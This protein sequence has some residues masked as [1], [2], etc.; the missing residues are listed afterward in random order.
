MSQT[1]G[2]GSNVNL[3]VAAVGSPPLS[4]Q[5]RFE[6]ADLPGGTSSTLEL[7]NFTSAREG[8]YEVVVSN[9]GGSANSAPAL[10]LLNNPVRIQYGAENC[11]YD[12][13]LTGPVGNTFILQTSSNLVNWTPV[14]TNTA[15]IGIMEVHDSGLPTGPARFFRA[16]SIP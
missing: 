16:A 15:P 2:L 10:A 6:G 14:V 5:W 11:R 1:A 12:L 13:R 4:Y 8:L 7:T 9:A 3:R